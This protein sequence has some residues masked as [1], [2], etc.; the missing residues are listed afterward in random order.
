MKA[1]Y[2]AASAV[3]ILCVFGHAD[4]T[5]SHNPGVVY[6]IWQ[7]IPMAGGY[8]YKVGGSTV[9]ANARRD[10]LQTGN[11][12]PLI[13]VASFNVNDCYNGETAAHNAAVNWH[14]NGGG[15][16]EW[17]HVTNAQYINFH[18]TIQNTVNGMEAETKIEEYEEE[19][20]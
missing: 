3:I 7:N 9:G 20:G 19:L 14:Y 15:G 8:F 12:F 5:C 1:F 10:A 4:A 16:T 11:P 18:N 17:Y 2:L 13:V 6:I